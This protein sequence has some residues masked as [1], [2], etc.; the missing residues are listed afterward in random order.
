MFAH[1]NVQRDVTLLPCG[2]PKD[3]EFSRSPSKLPLESHETEL[4]HM[5]IPEPMA[6]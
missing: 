5:T 2:S 1:G 4:V 6:G 3:A